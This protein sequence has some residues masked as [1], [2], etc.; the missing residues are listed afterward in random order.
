ML[1]VAL[2]TIVGILLSTGILLLGAFLLYGKAA[3]GPDVI[4]FVTVIAA[5]GAL[6]SLLIYAPVLHFSRAFL[7]T[8]SVP[9]GAFF[10]AIPL[11]L[12]VFI[13]IAVGILRGGMFAAGEGPLI[14]A[15]FAVLG[16]IVGWAYTRKLH[17]TN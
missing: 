3:W 9:F 14:A 11:N 7:R 13:I 15:A 5:G 16:A 10:G 17:S 8:R 2:A 12:P 4:G 1:I 6:L